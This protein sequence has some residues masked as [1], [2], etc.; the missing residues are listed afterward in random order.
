MALR[1]P[2]DDV[3]EVARPS[4]AYSTPVGNVPDY[5]HFVAG[6]LRRTQLLDQPTHCAIGIDVVYVEK[7]VER[8]LQTRLL[9]STR[10]IVGVAVDCV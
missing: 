9:K 1:V 5:P 6:F 2:V 10:Q 7:A 3:V 4:S 8:R